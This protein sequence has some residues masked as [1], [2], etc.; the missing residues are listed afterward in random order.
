MSS[1]DV[2]GEDIAY[3][4]DGDEFTT[5]IPGAPP[6]YSKRCYR[7]LERFLEENSASGSAATG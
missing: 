1:F 2:D 6:L 7:F 4:I 5:Y 3:C